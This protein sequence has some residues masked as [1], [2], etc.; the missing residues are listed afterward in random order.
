MNP[1]EQLKQMK[2]LANKLKSL[3]DDPRPGSPIWVKFYGDTMKA[4]V[5]F[6]DDKEEE[7]IKQIPRL[8]EHMVNK[9]FGDNG[10]WGGNVT[11]AIYLVGSLKPKQ[12]EHFISMFMVSFEI[13]LRELFETDDMAVDNAPEGFKKFAKFNTSFGGG[14]RIDD[15]QIDD[16]VENVI[17]TL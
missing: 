5:D 8:V 1:D 11:E 9:E 15:C 6:W 14:F 16:S 13:K 7:N 3:V 4:L 2:K 17:T 12:R 10:T